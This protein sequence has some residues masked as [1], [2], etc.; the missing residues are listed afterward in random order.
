MLAVLD[1]S[2]VVGT[3]TRLPG[4]R[5]RLDYA[6]TYRARSDAIPLSLSLPTQVRSHSDAAVTPWLWG[7][8]P[9]SDA[10]LRRWA[11]Q[12]HAAA[13]SP[14]SLL[15]TPLGEDC[16]GAFRF[17]PPEGVTTALHRA[18]R[19]EWL[20]ESQVADRLRELR[21]DATTWLGQDF[22]G[23]FSL[24][25]AGRAGLTVARTQL[26]TFDGES[27]VVVERYDR[28]M[29]GEGVVRV[30][31][32][33]LCQ[34]LGVH[35][36][37]KYQSEGGPGPAGVTALLRRAMPPTIADDAEWRFADA[38]A[39]NWL[40]AGT[41]AHAKNYSLLIAPGQV[42]LAP[43]YDIA[44]ALP[45][46]THE[47][48]LRLAMKLGGDDR[49]TTDR[50]PWPRTATELGVDAAALAD[51]VRDLARR[52][53]DAFAEAAA[54]PSISA[55]GRDFP[56]RLTGLVAERAA[57]CLRAMETTSAE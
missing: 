1:S 3:L 37:R 16:A 17:V 44:S 32:E 34:A 27:A 50:N 6:E 51:R 42:R 22:A 31:Q 33:D 2:G 28:V 30:H 43:L 35:P 19:V 18:G 14:F 25:A 29:T 55:L 38:L 53:P 12:F 49:L 24:D 57:R 13:T 21:R 11:R 9:E 39:W 7:L 10:V 54:A 52:T 8:L 5:L 56:D 47:K 20:T 4:S 23:K 45:Y 40:I 46:G 15:A 26:A 41:D 36:E 48:K